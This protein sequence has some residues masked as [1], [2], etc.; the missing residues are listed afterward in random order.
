MNIISDKFT[1][2][3]VLCKSR[4]NPG[5]QYYFNTRTRESSWIKPKAVQEKESCSNVAIKVE[6]NRNGEKN[7]KEQD[8]KCCKKSKNDVQKQ[9][10]KPHNSISHGGRQ[11]HL[12]INKNKNKC[13]Q[14]SKPAKNLAKN[15]LTK[16]RI[17]LALELEQEK[18]GNVSKSEPKVEKTNKAETPTKNQR[19]ELNSPNFNESNCTITSQLSNDSSLSPSQFFA[20]NKII[21][22][23]KAQLPEEYDNKD[24]QK[25]T[26]ADIEQGI[27]SKIIGYPSNV[28]PSTPP[29]FSQADKLLSAIKSKLAY[30]LPGKDK[31]DTSET[32]RMQMLRRLSDDM[33][34]TRTGRHIEQMD[35]DEGVTLVYS[36]VDAHKPSSSTFSAAP[37][38]LNTIQT[39]AVI[40]VDT[41]IFIHDLHCITQVLN[42]NIKGY[43]EQPTL[44]V[45][46]RVINEL[47]KLKDNNNGNGVLCKRAKAAMDFLYKSLPVANRLKGQSLRDSNS[48]IFPC[49]VPDDEILNCCLQQAE[50]GKSVVLLSNDKNLCSKAVVNGVATCGAAE[51]SAR[52]SPAPH[53]H[54]ALAALAALHHCD[55][56]IYQLLANILETE[57]RARYKALWEHVV[58]RPPPWQLQDVLFALLK[59]W[60][61]VFHE[62]FPRIEGLLNDLKKTYNHIKNK[63]P[64]TLV[65]AEVCNFKELC[66]E[67]AKKCQIIPEYMELAKN[68]VDRLNNVRQTRGQNNI[69]V[70]QAFE[71]VWIIFSSYC[72]KLCRCV[73]IPHSIEDRLPANEPVETLLSKYSMLRNHI[74]S[75]NHT[76]Q[77]VLNVDNSSEL[78]EGR[79]TNL[80]TELKSSL[81]LNGGESGVISRDELNIFCTKNR[82]LLQDATA[83]L[84][85]L[86]ELLD[87]CKNNF[88]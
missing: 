61:A 49:E 26:F 75:F 28:H 54:L 9:K 60:I 34:D 44:L 51:L 10:P 2:C 1:D 86:I 59:H 13:S 16:L 18:K 5:K 15:R 52:V 17:Q 81:N 25:D 43:T 6:P 69:S 32:D 19:S 80:E 11:N 78:L 88:H 20:A 7:R 66:I 85:T 56:T 83:N 68:T 29:Q 84:S 35:V 74:I 82:D 23:M 12:N 77:G 27:C 48:H 47:D 39:N 71:T 40:V 76:I 70:M 79:I 72:A 65:E 46:W 3:W 53:A 14:S 67:V 8:R 38:M 55:R 50:R 31:S 24:V 4:S 58:C 45:P 22:S 41:N 42:S 21:S 64:K 62:V 33:D 30:K 87:V 57:M 63:D 73:G 37:N 36:R